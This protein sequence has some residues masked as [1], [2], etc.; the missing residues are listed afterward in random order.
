MIHADKK[1]RDMI[2]EYFLGSGQS[3][4]CLGHNLDGVWFADI[5]GIIFE[6]GSCAELFRILAG[7][8]EE[9]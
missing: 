8:L 4:M 7:I 2:R 3:S 6:A 9:S 1:D 5:Y